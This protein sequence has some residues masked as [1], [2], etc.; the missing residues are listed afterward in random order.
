MATLQMLA[1]ELDHIVTKLADLEEGDEVADLG[2]KALEKLDLQPGDKVRIQYTDG[3]WDETVIDTDPKTGKVG[4][5]RYKA[6]TWSDPEFLKDLWFIVQNK[7]VRNTRWI[8]AQNIVAVVE[9]FAE[10]LKGYKALPFE[11][12]PQMSAAIE[13]DGY[14]T[15]GAFLLSNTPQGARRLGGA[16]KDVYQDPNTR[17]F[18]RR[19]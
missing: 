6:H 14:V 9:R 16:K 17:L 4:I 11:V 18:W 19:F 13:N 7:T 5:K 1:A 2:R 10:T 8:F 3:I 12:T 15:T